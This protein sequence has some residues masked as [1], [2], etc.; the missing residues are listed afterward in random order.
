MDL[1]SLIPSKEYV[2]DCNPAAN[3]TIKSKQIPKRNMINRRI[4]ILKKF[5][6][7]LRLY[8]TNIKAQGQSQ[9]L[10]PVNQ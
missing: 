8:F 4:G 9:R 6:M 3:S 7:K 10:S 5:N 2:L 1:D